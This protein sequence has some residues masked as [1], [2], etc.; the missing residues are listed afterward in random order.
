MKQTCRVCRDE[1]PGLSA[2]A[3]CI[4][5]RPSIINT[6][7]VTAETTLVQAPFTALVGIHFL[8]AKES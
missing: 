6:H 8:Q 7:A 1:S 4:F 5:L 2:S 3:S